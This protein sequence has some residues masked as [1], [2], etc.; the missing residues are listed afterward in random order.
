M[1]LDTEQ[2]EVLQFVSAG[3]NL[4]ITGQA[5]VEKSRLVATI[6]KTC[7][8]RN[9]KVALVCSSGIACNVFGS[10]LAST[11]QSIL[12]LS[13]LGVAHHLIK[14]KVSHHCS[15]MLKYEFHQSCCKALVPH[16]ERKHYNIRSLEAESSVL[17][18]A[19]IELNSLIRMDDLTPVKT[20][21]T[22][23]ARKA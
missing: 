22:T 23:E 10:G 16:E 19:I 13:E 11:S 18:A 2:A 3:H 8:L 21:T 9:L 12:R 5:R 4:L 1:A 15:L 7:E 20:K 14:R 17:F 6:V